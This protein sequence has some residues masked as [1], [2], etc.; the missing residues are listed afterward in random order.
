MVFCFSKEGK[1]GVL[2][3]I[4]LFI[5]S[6]QF[7]AVTTISFSLAFV[8]PMFFSRVYLFRG[9]RVELVRLLV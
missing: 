6:L 1:V 8:A 5:L 4:F 3:L 9:I 2:V 7:L